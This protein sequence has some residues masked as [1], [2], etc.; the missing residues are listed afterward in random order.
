MLQSFVKIQLRVISISAANPS[1]AEK[2]ASFLLF[3]FFCK[4]KVRSCVFCM[5]ALSPLF[6][7]L[8]LVFANKIKGLKDKK[9]KKR[10]DLY[11]K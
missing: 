10:L 2:T 5:F 9:K 7:L 8:L 6:H 1:R 4:T 11:F 3:E